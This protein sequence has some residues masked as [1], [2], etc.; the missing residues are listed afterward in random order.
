MQ[1]E[2]YQKGFA[3]LYF[4]KAFYDK[5][6]LQETAKVFRPYASITLSEMG[7]YYIIR[8]AENDPSFTQKEIGDAFKEYLMAVEYETNLQANGL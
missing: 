7:T 6:A 4:S 8:I 3:F 5:T 1:H 2:I